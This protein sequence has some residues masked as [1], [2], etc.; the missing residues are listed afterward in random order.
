MS[1][2]TSINFVGYTD[3]SAPT[4]WRCLEHGP[5]PYPPD[6]SDANGAAGEMSVLNFLLLVVYGAAKLPSAACTLYAR[7]ER[8]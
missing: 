7:G 1:T 8:C 6:R 2:P 3:F 5:P 4:V